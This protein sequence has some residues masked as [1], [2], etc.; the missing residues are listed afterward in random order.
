MNAGRSEDD[1][2]RAAAYGGE[3][4]SPRTAGLREE[5]GR[6]WS[7]CGVNTEWSPLKAV[8][9]HRPGA[10]LEKLSDPDAI[11]ESIERA[12]AWSEVD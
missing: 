12:L 7:T 1:L 9:L 4:W 6:L 10:E 5:I 8:L 11:L 3:R 2:A